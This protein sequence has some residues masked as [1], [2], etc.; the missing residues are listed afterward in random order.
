MDLFDLAIASKLS[1]GG[2]GSY[3]LLGSAEVSLAS[4]TSTATQL[5]TFAWPD[6]ISPF[7]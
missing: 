3:T 6:G 7:A 4:V 5:Y 1:G 2:G